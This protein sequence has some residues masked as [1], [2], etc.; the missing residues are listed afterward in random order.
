MPVISL[1]PSLLNPGKPSSCES[2]VAEASRPWASI[3]TGAVPAARRSSSSRRRGTPNRVRSPDRAPYRPRPGRTPRGSATGTSRCRTTNAPIGPVERLERPVVG[4]RRGLRELQDAR[5]PPKPPLFA[6]DRASVSPV[7]SKKN[8]RTAY[9]AGTCPFSGRLN[10]VAVGRL[11]ERVRV[12]G[13]RPV[14]CPCRGW[15]PTSSRTSSRRCGDPSRRPRGRR[16]RPD[17]RG[18]RSA[19]RVCE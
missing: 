11:R 2:N 5:Y 10:G 3:R 9:P 7:S 13:R 6:C 14:R 17:R 19:G 18:T 12:E 8:S 4:A 1:S 15:S 16:H